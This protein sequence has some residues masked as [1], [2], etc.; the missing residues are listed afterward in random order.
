MMHELWCGAAIF[1]IA[2]VRQ[3]QTP[4]SAQ[5]AQLL[6]SIQKQLVWSHYPAH[7][8]SHDFQ[9]AGPLPQ[10]IW[11]KLELTMPV[12]RLTCIQS[13]VYSQG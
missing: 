3:Q 5:P 9:P 1:H 8:E 7:G 4:I 13:L 6:S 11:A 2:V 10:I 12:V